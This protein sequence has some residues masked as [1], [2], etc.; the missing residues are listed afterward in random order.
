MYPQKQILSRFALK[1]ARELQASRA[2]AIVHMS[3]PSDGV[4]EAVL[5]F[6][7]RFGV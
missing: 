1:V 7:A 4:V 5:E 6:A 2:L 3:D